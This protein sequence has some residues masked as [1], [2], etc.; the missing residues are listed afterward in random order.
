MATQGRREGPGSKGGPKE[1]DLLKEFSWNVCTFEIWN[2]PKRDY[3][4]S[5][6][7]EN[8]LEFYL[9]LG[10]KLLFWD[11]IGCNFKNGFFDKV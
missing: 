5:W 1:R 7:F 11:Q 8:L 4:M 3:E 9:I 10:H 2:E 6:N